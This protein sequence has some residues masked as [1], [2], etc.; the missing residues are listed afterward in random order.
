MDKYAAI[1]CEFENV[2]GKTRIKSLSA[3]WT[4]REL[5]YTLQYVRKCTNELEIINLESDFPGQHRIIYDDEFDSIWI[6]NK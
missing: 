4:E 6:E 2:D 3:F 5:P 1:D